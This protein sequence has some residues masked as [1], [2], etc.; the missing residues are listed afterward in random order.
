MKELGKGLLASEGRGR[1]SI[2]PS[3]SAN[4]DSRR[5]SET[6]PPTKEHIQDGPR[7]PP[8]MEYMC[9]SDFMWVLQ[10]LEQAMS[11]KVL[12]VQTVSLT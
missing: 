4:L 10:Q 1:K 7:P 11:I 12:S 6:E 8:Y 2:R 9:Y 3:E 5:L